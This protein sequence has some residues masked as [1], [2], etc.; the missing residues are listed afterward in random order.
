MSEY[1]YVKLECENH[2]TTSSSVIEHKEIIDEHAKNG[3]R[4]V[5]YIP[6][7]MGPSGKILSLDLIFENNK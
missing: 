6:T 1:K 7:K 5:G 3:Y 2:K 4:Y